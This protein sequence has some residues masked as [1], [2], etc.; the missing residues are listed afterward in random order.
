[1]LAALPGKVAAELAPEVPE[2]A[3]GWREYQE[4]PPAPEK[5]SVLPWVIGIGGLAVLVLWAA[6]R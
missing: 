4:L 2:Q 5:A 6:R 1:M 3:P